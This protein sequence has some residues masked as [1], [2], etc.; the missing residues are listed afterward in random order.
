MPD[1]L[2]REGHLAI[3]E[4]CLPYYPNR[5]IKT[6]GNVLLYYLMDDLKI[7]CLFK[8]ICPVMLTNL[9]YEMPLSFTN[10]CRLELTTRIFINN[11]GRH[12]KWGMIFKGEERAYSVSINENM[13]LIHLGEMLVY[14]IKQF[15]LL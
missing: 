7:S 4:K 11:I 13:L 6:K 15:F 8:G 12:Q 10:I 9:T 3:T 2:I 5:V 1:N 14:H